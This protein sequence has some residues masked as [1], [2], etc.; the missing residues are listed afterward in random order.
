MI[1]LEKLRMY[2]L[3]SNQNEEMLKEIAYLAEEKTYPDGHPIFFEGEMA[4]RL[5]LIQEG[6]VMITMNM[7][8]KGEQE[9]TELSPL[10]KG[11]IAGWS[12]IIEPHIYKL[13]GITDKETQL[14]VFEGT[15]LRELFDENPIAGYF[16]LKKLSEVIGNRLISKC[17]EVMSMYA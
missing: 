7:G 14:I 16:F 10:G 4:N 13:G 9:V 1:S 15:A 17:S 2:P 6:S 12:S 5:F 8:K 3:F 11:E